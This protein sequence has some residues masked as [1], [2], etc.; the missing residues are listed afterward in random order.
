MLWITGPQIE[1]KG[2]KLKTQV[3]ASVLAIAHSCSVFYL[4]RECPMLGEETLV[5]DHTGLDPDYGD[6]ASKG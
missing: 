6:V 1:D 5:H 3:K 4:L 2:P